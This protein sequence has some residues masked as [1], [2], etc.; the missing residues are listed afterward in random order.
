M[1]IEKNTIKD[2]NGQLHLFQQ[3][4]RKNAT[5]EDLLYAMEDNAPSVLNPVPE[6]TESLVTV[7]VA[8]TM[9]APPATMSVSSDNNMMPPPKNAP[10]PRQSSGS[11]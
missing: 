11:R 4:R 8:M 10:P 6:V 9:S 7:P 5:P 2:S 1:K 3:A